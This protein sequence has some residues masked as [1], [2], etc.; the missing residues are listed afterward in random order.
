MSFNSSLLS[1]RISAATMLASYSLDVADSY[2][3]V[4]FHLTP[5]YIRKIAKAIGIAERTVCRAL[6]QI[7]RVANFLVTHCRRLR[8]DFTAN[9]YHICSVISVAAQGVDCAF[10]KQRTTGMGPE[11]RA[12]RSPLCA[13]IVN[14]KEQLCNLFPR[15]KVLT[16][17]A[18]KG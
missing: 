9:N 16:K 13:F 12:K 17:V 2:K 8:G 1:N 4:P 5:H 18:N 10:A 3:K 15:V 11:R 6:H 7:K 14:L